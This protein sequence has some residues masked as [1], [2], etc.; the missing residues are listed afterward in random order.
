MNTFSNHN[1]RSYP[2]L[3]TPVEEENP[4]DEKLRGFKLD[5]ILMQSNIEI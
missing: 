1:A 5:L 4:T 3:K 2:G